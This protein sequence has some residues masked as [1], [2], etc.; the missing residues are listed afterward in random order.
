[1]YL[2]NWIQDKIEKVFLFCT[3]PDK[4]IA[5]ALIIKFKYLGEFEFVFENN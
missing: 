1:M 4:K 3:S 5:A 2:N